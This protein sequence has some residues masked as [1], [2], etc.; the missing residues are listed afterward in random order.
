MGRTGW[1][2]SKLTAKTYLLAW[3]LS[4]TTIENASADGGKLLSQD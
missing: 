1:V 3:D 2:E 4:A